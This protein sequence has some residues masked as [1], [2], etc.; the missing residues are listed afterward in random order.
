MSSRRRCAI[1]SR[2]PPRATVAFVEREAVDL[3]PVQA[4]YRGGTHVFGV[5]ADGAPDLHHREVLLVLDA[6]AYW[7]ELRGVSVRG[8]A[9]RVE[10][11]G[12]GSSE[13]LVWY[14]VT[15]GACSPG[16]TTRFT[17]S[18]PCCRPPTRSCVASFRAR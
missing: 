17:R 2:D 1:C 10:S 18:E 15:P 12:A 3:V 9:E 13:R 8:V 7:F 6:G 16:T 14:A 5:V 4:C 11:P